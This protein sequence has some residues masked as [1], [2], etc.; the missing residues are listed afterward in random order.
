MTFEQPLW[1]LCAIPALGVAAYAWIA[2]YHRRAALTFPGGGLLKSRSRITR[3]LPT[4]LPIILKTMALLLAIAA[5]ARPQMI[6]REAVGLAE[7]IDILLVLDTSISMLAEDFEPYNRMH[8]ALEAAR[9]FIGGRISDRIGILVFGSAPLLTTPLTLDHSALNEFLEEIEPGM[10]D[11]KGTAIGDGIAAGVNHLKETASK[12]KVMILLT[13]GSSNTGLLDPITAAKLAQTYDIKI[14]AIGTAKR[15]AAY[16]TVNG[17]RVQMSDDLDE[18]TLLQVASATR[19]R[20]FRATNAQQLKEIYKEI[21][22][23]EKHT[24][25]KPEFISRTDVYPLF[26]LPAVFLL[27]LEMLLSRTLLLRIP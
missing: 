23:L 19:G 15:G 12:S 4:R 25:D 9:N 20:Y 10:V 8:A 1:L 3:F 18:D 14:Y 17:Q 11:Q 13:D 27:A 2:L 16:A 6:S 24:F 22:S 21:D 26:L 5:F 7:G